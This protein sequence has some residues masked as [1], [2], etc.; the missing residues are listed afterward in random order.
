MIEQ[1]VL[2]EWL[3]HGVTIESHDEAGIYNI[4][5]TQTDPWG[6]EQRIVLVPAEVQMLIA[7]ATK[8]LSEIKE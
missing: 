6:M 2:A 5:L 4:A 8:W 3:H 1:Q 7:H